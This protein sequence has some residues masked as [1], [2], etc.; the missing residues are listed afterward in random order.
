MRTRRATPQS[1]CKLGNVLADRPLDES[2][3]IRKRLCL[4]SIG[5]YRSLDG[6]ATG[7]TTVAQTYENALEARS[8]HFA[9]RIAFWIDF[10]NR[11]SQACL[12]DAVRAAA[13]FGPPV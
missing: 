3:R 13:I 6:V 4:V 8:V 12:R 2:R 5:L 9:V 1:R 10:S 7:K 11:L